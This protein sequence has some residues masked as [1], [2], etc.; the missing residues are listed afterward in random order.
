MANMRFI[1]W[2]TALAAIALSSFAAWFASGRINLE[3][4]S[5][6]DILSARDDPWFSVRTPWSV[7]CWC[8]ATALGIGC[9]LASWFARIRAGWVLSAVAIA[10]VA[11]CGI[12]IMRSG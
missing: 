7:A 4:A 6:A 10:F 3:A 9:I 12:I 2:F 5:Y 11:G 1:P 8:V